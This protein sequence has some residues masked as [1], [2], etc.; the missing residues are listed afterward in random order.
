[1]VGGN[2][3]PPDSP[4]VVDAGPDVTGFEGDQAALHGTATDPEHDQLTIHWTYATGPDVDP[5]TQCFFGDPTAADTTIRCTDDG[6]I[7]VT[8]NAADAYHDDPSVD[9]AT[10]RLSNVA[11]IIR[12]NAGPAVR[13]N[14]DPVLGIVAPR[15]WQLFRVGDPVTLTTNY[16]DP[17]SN[18]TQSCAVVW[19]DGTTSSSAG[20]GTVCSATHRYTHA[21]MYTI[22]PTIT[23]DDGGVSDATNVMVVVY[24]P[25]AGVA[26]GNGWLNQSGNGGFDF[27]SSYPLRSA[28]V[29]DGAVTFAL[30]PALNL[31]LRN[32]QHLEWLV[33][34]PDGKIAVKGTAERV[35]GQ[36]VGFVLYGY[37]GCPSGVTSGCQPG[38]SRL[39][40]VVWDVTANGPIPDGVPA[41]YDNRAGHSFD[42]DAADPQ[43]I[44][45]GTILIQ[46]PPIG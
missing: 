2:P 44:A 7:T 41:I 46:H 17:G 34:T 42:V 15:P 39:R 35:P 30:P 33:V 6:T 38:P 40:M 9:T 4:P 37:Y 29:P 11:P 31:N 28:T 32:H 13:P 21:G 25:A 12:R 10:A 20:T 36:N 14:A 16:V 23:D 26:Q 3:N 22:R 19:D 27:T 1:M 8:L 5:G 18:D 45:Q 43:T 24:D